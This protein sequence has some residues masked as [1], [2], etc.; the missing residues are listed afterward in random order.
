MAETKYKLTPIT[1]MPVAQTL[2]GFI[3]MGVDNRNRSVQV[4]IDMLKGNKGDSPYVG[5]NGNWWVGTVDTGVSSTPALSGEK[6]QDTDKAPNLKLFTDEIDGVI[7]NVSKQKMAV[8]ENKSDA[9]NAVDTIY[10]KRWQ[11]ISYILTGKKI[12]GGWVPKEYPILYTGKNIFQDGTLVDNPNYNV[13]SINV[14]GGVKLR[15]RTVVSNNGNG[16]AFYNISGVRISG[17][18]FTSGN[19]GDIREID[20]PT[21]AV[22]V[23]HSYPNDTYA[24]S[25][26]IPVFYTP[27]V[28]MNNIEIDDLTLVTE[29]FIGELPDLWSNDLYW[30][31]PDNNAE[32]Y[33][34][35]ESLGL[36]FTTKEEARAAVVDTKKGVGRIITYGFFEPVTVS[37]FPNK[38][39]GKYKKNDGSEVVNSSFQI[40]SIP[41]FGFN[42]I[43]HRMYATTSGAGGAFVDA[44]GNYISGYTF[45]ASDGA[46][47]DFKEI[48]VPANAA[49]LETSYY[50]DSAATSAGRPKWDYVQLYSDNVIYRWITEQ[51]TGDHIEEWDTEDNWKDILSGSG[52][53]DVITRNQECEKYVSACR[54]HIDPSSFEN[55]NETMMP[56]FAHTS[57]TH[58]DAVRFNN[59]VKYCEYIGVDAALVSGDQVTAIY[60]DDFTYYRNAV[61]ASSTKFFHVLGN[62]DC[63]QAESQTDQMQHARFFDGIDTRMGMVHEGKCYYYKDFEDKKIRLIGLNEFQQGGTIRRYKYYKDDQ[64]SWFVNTLKSTPA[65]YGIIIMMHQPS[66]E[67]ENNTDY[68]KF[69]QKE[70]YFNAFVSNMTGDIIGDIV[71]AFISRTSINKTYSQNGAQP[72]ITVN[73]DFSTS[74]A[75]GVEFIM[76]VN[77]HF[78]IDR[79]GYLQGTTN[80]QLC[81]NVITTQ[82]KAGEWNDVPRNGEVVQ[83]AFNFYGIDRSNGM[84][85]IARVGSNTTFEM[86][87]RDCMVIPYK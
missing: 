11:T 48:E 73:T 55:S 81:C 79:I 45:T 76:H 69:W 82:V 21:G 3:T 46:T 14:E 20:I 15:I 39:S 33:N 7:Y 56:F 59:F 4:S 26:G 64:I 85:R 61:M 18:T 47:G 62:H 10:K 1:D 6:G 38:V 50:T 74:V 12:T 30:A 16:G 2:E 84:V 72:T 35:T 34:I 22:E 68:K 51:F 28:Y 71:D 67:W 87:R 60:T 43:R 5:E 54:K 52:A 17:Y 42:R 25:L 8:Y 44:F 24:S 65:E 32:V 23:R 58:S 27:D 75:D 40:I 57:D 37:L 53:Q 31:E 78:H 86:E 13:H 66:R 41:V 70:R 36:Y 83:D 77:G 63:E 19:H 29:Q 9:R 49:T 80:M